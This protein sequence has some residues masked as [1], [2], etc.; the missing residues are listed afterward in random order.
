MNH[1]KI[2]IIGILYI[3]FIPAFVFLFPGLLQKMDTIGNDSVKAFQKVANASENSVITDTQKN[4]FI[5]T[6][7]DKETQFIWSK[8]IKKNESYSIKMAF[9]LE[10][11]EKAG[12]DIEKLPS[13]TIQNN[14]IVIERTFKAKTSL[15]ESKTATNSYKNIM[16]LNRESIKYHESLDHYGI[17]FMNGN[18]LEWARDIEKNDKDLVFVLNP[19]P[20][21]K[22]GVNVNQIEGWSYTK[23]SHMDHG[24]TVK[25]YKLIKSF[26]LTEGKEA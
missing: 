5:L 10:P 3:I 25:V 6:T 4:H 24:K 18:M 9:S 15:E 26:S 12:L 17:D 20:F 21:I 23:V 13:K 1:K 14:K 19:E 7:K 16:E 8:D 11:F 22:A 2:Y